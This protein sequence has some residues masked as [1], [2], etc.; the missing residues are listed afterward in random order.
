MARALQS[1]AGMWTTIENTDGNNQSATN[2][3]TSS[4]FVDP[5]E[6]EIEIIADG[7]N[8]S[9][10]LDTQGGK[11]GWALL[12]LLGVPLPLLLIAYLIWGR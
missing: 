1:L 10:Q 3:S 8:Q 11:I 9:R 5:Y 12:W 2:S 7:D 6:V 4:Q